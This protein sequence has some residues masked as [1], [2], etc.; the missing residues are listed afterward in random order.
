MFR[1]HK[2]PQPPSVYVCRGTK[3]V[4]SLLGL[5]FG[6]SRVWPAGREVGAQRAPRLLELYKILIIM[7]VTMECV[8]RAL[9]WKLKDRFHRQREGRQ[10]Q[11]HFYW[12]SQNLDIIYYIYC[13]WYI[14][15]SKGVTVDARHHCLMDLFVRFEF[16]AFTAL[17]NPELFGLL[18]LISETQKQLLFKCALSSKYIWPTTAAAGH[19]ILDEAKI[20]FRAGA[21]SLHIHLEDYQ[22]SKAIHFDQ[23]LIMSES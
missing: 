16:I 20:R 19:L 1:V 14:I 2:I 10:H 13:S 4:P 3:L 22:N 11:L 21:A 23:Y 17:D 9:S 6:G 5:G 12:I 7:A 15:C 8:H 18:V